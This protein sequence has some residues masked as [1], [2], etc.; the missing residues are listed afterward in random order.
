MII[1]FSLT[2]FLTTLAAFLYVAAVKTAALIV[3]PP[4][5]TR[6]FDLKKMKEAGFDPQAFLDSLPAPEKFECTSFDGTL[7]GGELY[8]TG[9]KGVCVFCHGWNGN[10]FE[11]LKYGPVY[12]NL[13]FSLVFYNHRYSG[14]HAGKGVLCTMGQNESL[15]L[16]CVCR[17]VSSL[18][19]PGTK[20][21][22]HGESMGASCVLMAAPH[23]ENLTF[24]VEDCGFSSMREE[25]IH[26]IRSRKAPAS[27]IIDI[28]SSILKKR[29]SVDMDG[30]QPVKDVESI[31][32][33]VLF[34]HGTGDTFVPSWMSEKL[35]ESKKKGVRELKLFENPYHAATVLRYPEE[36]S[37]NIE[38][39]VRKNCLD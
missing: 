15:D 22:L 11:M 18:F 16:E 26:L 1:A 32:C 4:L 37:A 27:P 7:L 17:T 8:R 12:R 28:I 39:F 38:T 34:I 2:I 31:E 20:L 13:G 36:Y 24:C 33:P 35:F 30:V 5:A 9:E 21:A 19:P 10:S 25:I 29:Y 23:I 14:E 6:E 3:R